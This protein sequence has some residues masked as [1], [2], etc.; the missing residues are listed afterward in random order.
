MGRT[1][2]PA[3][4]VL[5]HIFVAEHLFK[6]PT[7]VIHLDHLVSLQALGRSRGQKEFVDTSAQQFARGHRVGTRG[8]RLPGDDHT[9][10]QREIRDWLQ[11]I[12][13]V[14]HIEEFSLHLRFRMLHTHIT[15][16]LQAGSYAWVVEQLVVTP[17]CQKAQSSVLD[18]RE[19]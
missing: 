15:R 1:G 18:P 3:I 12:R 9:A 13:D 8:R 17:P 14:A 5:L 2:A 6:A 4:R 16:V 10:G 11:P 7:L 19:G